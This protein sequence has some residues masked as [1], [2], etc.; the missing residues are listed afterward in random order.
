MLVP[1]KLAREPSWNIDHE[2][3]LP[4]CQRVAACLLIGSVPTTLKYDEFCMAA[5]RLRVMSVSSALMMAVSRCL[6]LC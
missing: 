6:G 3:Q 4:A 1:Q 2:E 5:M